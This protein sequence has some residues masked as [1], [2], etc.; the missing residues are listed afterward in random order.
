MRKQKKCSG[1]SLL[2]PSRA[3]GHS[4]WAAGCLKAPHALEDRAPGMLSR[5]PMILK[6]DQDVPKAPCLEVYSL[7]LLSRVTTPL[8]TQTIS[9]PSSLEHLLEKVKNRRF[10][11]V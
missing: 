7:S 3:L 4:R 6:I 8:R 10:L 2:A 1:G 11:L 5:H 9:L